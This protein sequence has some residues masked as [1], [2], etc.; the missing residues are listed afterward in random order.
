M[1][2]KK[3]LLKVLRLA[4]DIESMGT[5]ELEDQ[6]YAFDLDLTDEDIEELTD[7]LKKLEGDE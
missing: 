2:T 5:D 7:S 6:I 3:K 1:L 4:L